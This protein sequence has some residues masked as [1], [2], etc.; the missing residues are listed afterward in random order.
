MTSPSRSLSQ[1]RRGYAVRPDT[2]SYV[3]LTPKRFKAYI[4]KYYPQAKVEEHTMFNLGRRYKIVRVTL[5]QRGLWTVIVDHST[6]GAEIFVKNPSAGRTW[7]EIRPE[8]ATDFSAAL[9]QAVLILG[10]VGSHWTE[11]VAA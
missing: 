10:K 5:F 8:D 3:A 4:R 6:L 9:Q 11:R 1:K 7:V 2:P